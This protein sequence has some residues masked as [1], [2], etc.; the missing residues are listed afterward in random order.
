MSWHLPPV[1]SWLR[2]KVSLLLS[3]K[4]TTSPQGGKAGS[5]QELLCGVAGWLQNCSLPRDVASEV[6]HGLC[7]SR[8]SG[9]SVSGYSWAVSHAEVDSL[10][11]FVMLLVSSW[12]LC[13]LQSQTPDP[14]YE[15]PGRRPRGFARQASTLP[16]ELQLQPRKTMFKTG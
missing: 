9:A 16:T 11:S 15:V 8:K 1:R 5:V 13:C 10:L 6:S 4:T 2:A 14:V 12:G 3:G 7:R